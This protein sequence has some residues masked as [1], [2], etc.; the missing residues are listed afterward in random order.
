[1][2]ILLSILF[3][4]F[5]QFGFAQTDSNYIRINF[6]YGSKPA[7]GFKAI[8]HKRFGGIKGGH[9][10]IQ[11]DGKCLDFGP[12]GNCHVFPTKKNPCGN[13]RISESL[14]WD[15]IKERSA[16]IV[17][18]VT[19]KQK[20]SLEKIFANYTAKAPID[21]AVFGFRC[22]S[23]TYRVLS[24]IGIT[25]KMSRLANIVSHFY[26]KLLRKKLYR[27][28]K[29]NNYFVKKNKGSNSRVWESDMGLL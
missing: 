3:I 2:K 16:Y 7:K 24:Y 28:A 8:E 25:H 23:A 9:V 19:K 11:V 5:L 1:M 4:L 6:L 10:N 12:N 15:S 22:A 29:E 27:W 21:Y 17:V 14:R 26:P 20:D 18:P 13:F